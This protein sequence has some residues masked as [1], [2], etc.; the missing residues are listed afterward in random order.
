MRYNKLFRYEKG[1]V[2]K[3][4]VIVDN[5][6][7]VETGMLP[8]AVLPLLAKELSEI[9]KKSS[10]KR[11]NPYRFDNTTSRHV[12]IEYAEPSLYGYEI[13]NKMVLRFSH[14][15]NF[16]VPKDTFIFDLVDYFVEIGLLDSNYSFIGNLD[17]EDNFHVADIVTQD[18][19][20]EKGFKFPA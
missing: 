12:H 11:V 9:C 6:F 5:N 20:L 14:K 2:Q 4:L 13:L 18:E 15:G 19:L 16:K 17:S 1:G 8:K 10:Y 3:R 7:K